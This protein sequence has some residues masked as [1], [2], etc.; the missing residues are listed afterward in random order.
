MT[1]AVESRI[2]R[3]SPAFE[4]DLRRNSSPDATRRIW[5][6]WYG[7]GVDLAI[8]VNGCR[9]G[10]PAAALASA[11]ATTVMRQVKRRSARAMNNAWEQDGR[12]G[13]FGHGCSRLHRLSRR[14]AAS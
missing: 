7:F 8:A 4:Q 14:P 6:L 11:I 3:I 5:P 12:S 10:S 13:D 9:N 2:R 1:L